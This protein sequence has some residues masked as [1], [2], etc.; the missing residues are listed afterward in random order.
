MKKL[1][2]IIAAAA[3][4]CSV[5]QASKINFQSGTVATYLQA[6]GTTNLDASYTFALGTFTESS[7]AGDLSTWSAGFNDEMDGVNTWKTSGPAPLQNKFQGEV[8]MDDN[9][10]A[11][12]AAYIFG[13]NGSDEIIIFRNAAWVFPTFDNLDTTADVFSLVD[14]NTQIVTA[15]GSWTAYASNI[16]ML[17]TVA[18]PEPS[19]FAALAGLCALG[20]VMVRRRRA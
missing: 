11:A 20:A 1:T 4:V 13:T 16:T 8:A 12:S 2:T 19:T 14:A 9:S 7:L 10:S 18:V 3:L 5:S 6:D 15:A 17:S